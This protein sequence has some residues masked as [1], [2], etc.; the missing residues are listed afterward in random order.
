MFDAKKMGKKIA[1]LRQKN[2]YTQENLAE[3]LGISSQA[4][5]KWENG[6]SDPST[7]NLIALA[8]LYG[9]S[10]EELLEGL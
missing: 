6:I 10:A 7:S 4:V 3:K 1:F 5:S 2:K 8:K 9:L